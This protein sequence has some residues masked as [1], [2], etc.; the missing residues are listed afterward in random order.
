MNGG[1]QV[2]EVRI[3]GERKQHPYRNNGVITRHIPANNKEHAKRKAT[4]RWKGQVLS[5]R[6][7]HREEIIGTLE[8]MGLEDIIGVDPR[9]DVNDTYN[10]NFTLDSLVFKPKSKRGL[11]FGRRKSAEEE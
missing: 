7:L 6:K 5:L 10:P 4:K 9:K 11:N 8:T 1:L 3:R 2:F